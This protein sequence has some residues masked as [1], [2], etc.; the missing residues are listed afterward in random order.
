MLEI[1][2]K[3]QSHIFFLLD[4]K[5]LSFFHMWMCMVLYFLIVDIHNTHWV[6][7]TS[8]RCLPVNL[9]PIIARISRNSLLETGGIFRNNPPDVFLYTE[10]FWKYVANLQKNTHAEEIH[11]SAWVLSA[12]LAAYFQDNV[13]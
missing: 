3:N 2:N 8:H 11:T 7:I 6:F 12:K 1:F 5:L 9:H 10:M 13:P 4:Q